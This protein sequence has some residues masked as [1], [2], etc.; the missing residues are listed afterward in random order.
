LFFA[1]HDRSTIHG[2]RLV[3]I[4]N[5]N[6][7]RIEREKLLNNDDARWLR[8]LKRVVGKRCKYFC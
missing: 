2:I 6:Y 8:S 7:P 5:V 4:N 3:W 1:L